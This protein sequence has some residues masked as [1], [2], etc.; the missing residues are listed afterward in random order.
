MILIEVSA[1]VAELLLMF[2]SCGEV[3]EK[4]KNDAFE[5][6][7][8]ENVTLFSVECVLGE[9]VMMDEVNK[10][11]VVLSEDVKESEERRRVPFST[12]QILSS[13]TLLAKVNEHDEK[14]ADVESVILMMKRG[15]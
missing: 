14:L 13:I 15:I 7:R 4:V 9:M 3:L 12:F 6:L 11:G 2:E 5:K 10:T 1:D 8:K